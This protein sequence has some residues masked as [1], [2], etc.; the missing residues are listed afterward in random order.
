MHG[1]VININ[2]FDYKI[3]KASQ[4]LKKPKG[5][6][7]SKNGKI[8]RDLV[9]AFDIETSRLKNINQSFMYIWQFQIDE[10][11]TIIGRTWEEFI[12]FLMHIEDIIEEDKL[13]VYVHNLSYEAQFLQGIWNF[14]PADI[15]CLK[16]PV[17]SDSFVEDM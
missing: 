17:L 16:S 3:I 5:K 1:N 9:C 12:T 7:K 11:Y 15:F 10:Y 8:Y 6:H 13:V 2:D 4:R 14:S